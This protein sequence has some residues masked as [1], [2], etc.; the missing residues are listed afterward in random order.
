LNH[1]LRIGLHL[2]GI[3]TFDVNRPGNV[4]GDE[5][6]ARCWSKYLA[7]HP[8]VGRIVLYGQ[9]QPH[10]GD[11]DLVIHF[12]PD[13]EGHPAARNFL[14]LQNVF[15]ADLFPGG[16]LGVFQKV[17]H[18]F[19]G[20]LF[21]SQR[22]MRACAPGAVIP[23]A[24]D[25]ELFRP[26][27]GGAPATAPAVA[28]GGSGPTAVG[29]LPATA[30]GGSGPIRSGPRPGGPAVTFVGNNIRGERCNQ[31]YLVPALPFGLAIYG[32][33]AWQA[34][35]V[36][37]CRGKV[38]MEE[39][40]ALYAG[41][42]VNLNAHIPDHVTFD[43]LNQRLYDILACGGF[44]ISDRIDALESVF[45]DAVLTTDGD[46][47][48]WAKLVCSLADGDDRRRRADKGRRLVLDRH[49]YAHRSA[50][51]VEFLQTA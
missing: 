29:K 44:V 38:P 32:N 13:L 8:A 7:R 4:Q 46:D 30:P 17:K 51:V 2:I 49:T 10:P 23:F 28:R 19:D 35:L 11:L 48:L 3:G 42:A 50:A 45:E 43:T 21:T 31:R 22:L 16:T 18:R 40:P 20:F 37:A 1:R 6:V 5:L 41:S 34:P 15:P 33:N 27:A 26:P 25:P 14:Y 36:A 47:D 12:H 9:G 24:T 39:L